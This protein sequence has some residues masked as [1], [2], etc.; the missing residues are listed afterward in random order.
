M[1]KTRSANKKSPSIEKYLKDLQKDVERGKATEHTFRPAH[2]TFVE[3][4]DTDLSAINEPKRIECGAPD[5]IILRNETPLGYIEAKDIDADL[6]EI[7]NSEQIQRYLKSLNNLIVTNYLEF[8]WYVHGERRLIASLGK[9]SGKNIRRSDDET[10]VAEL[11]ERFLEESAPVINSAADLAFRLAALAKTIKGAIEA[12]FEFESEDKWL[13]K[14]LKAFQ[15]VL[16]KDLNEED[17]ANMFA[18]TLAYG[19]FAARVHC[20]DLKKFSRVTAAHVLPR[21]NLFLQKL[22][23]EFAG[24]DMPPTISWAV[25]EI[26]ELLKKADMKEIL[27]GFGQQNGKKDPVIHF[28]ETFLQQYD[29]QVRDERGVYYTPDPVIDFIVNS[30]DNILIDKFDK[31]KGLADEET[32]ILDPALG[33]GSFLHAAIDRIHKRFS[34]KQGAWEDYVSRSLLDRMFG[35]EILMAPYAIAH[36]KLGLQLKDT[37]YDFKKDAR[38]GVYLTNTLEETAKRSQDLLFN[39]LADEASAASKIKIGSPIMVVIGNPPYNGHSANK[40]V[41]WINDLLRGYDSITDKK[42]SNYFEVDGKTLTELGEKNTK[43]LNNDYVKFIRFAHWRIET[44]GYGVVGFITPRS[45]LNGPTFRGMRDSLSKDFHEIYVLDIHG[46]KKEK[47]K[48]P[49]GTTDDNVFDIETGVAIT[50]FVRNKAPLAGRAQIFHSD[51]WGV[52]DHKYAWLKKNNIK[53][54]EWKNVTPRAPDYYFTPRTSTP[55]TNGFRIN[56][57]FKES[58]LGVLTKRDSLTIAFTKAELTENLKFFKDSK[59]SDKSVA[60]KF[61]VP[62]KDNDKWNLSKAREDVGRIRDEEIKEIIYRPLDSRAIFYNDTLV[63][64]TNK[65]VMDHLTKPPMNNRALV[66]GRQGQSVGAGQW[67]VV[68]CTNGLIDQNIFRRGGGTVFPL[69]DRVNSKKSELSDTLFSD[70]FKEFISGLTSKG[71][72][73]HGKNVT[74]VDLFNYTYALLHSSLYRKK[75]SESMKDKFPIIP[76]PESTKLLKDLAEKGDELFLLHTG[77]SSKSAAHELDFPTKGT[78]LIEMHKFDPKKETV[79]I[80]KLQEIGGISK[81]AWALE[82]GGYPVIEKWLKDRKKTTLSDLTQL[83]VVVGS[84]LEMIE[85]MG[86]IDATIQKHGGITFDVAAPAR[87]A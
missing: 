53:T 12:T 34:K 26:V 18:E 5:F 39:W 17:F 13:R 38:L 44:T 82:I 47:E 51:L 35:F 75:Y 14:W 62:L 15:E 42:V 74:P 76:F 24:P 40:K 70:E 27:K 63:A 11:F 37:G 9:I 50:L 68:Y 48:C 16:I 28:Y 1:K 52:R 77:E 83:E 84:C 60:E 4:F 67:N 46:D 6:D 81:E 56:E 58:S 65:R 45:Y 25:D 78:N 73:W 32:L 85:V 33:T 41:K 86:A 69:F 29:A 54:V 49:D 31:K 21:T 87:A 22:F 80:N 20:T 55:R 79:K 57:M 23:H 64:R 43:W 59:N 36:L 72:A 10:A 8:R 71:G 61:G 7:E 66:V 19:L 2:K 3:A 30:V